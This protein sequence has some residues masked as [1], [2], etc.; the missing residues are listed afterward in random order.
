MSVPGSNL[1]RQALK[2]ITPQTVKYFRF[3]SRTLSPTGRDVSTFETGVDVPQGSVQAVPLS[4]YEMLGLDRQKRYVT[5]FVVR[6]VLGVGRDYSGDQF[7]WG[8]K[9]YDV[10]GETNWFLQDGWVAVIGVEL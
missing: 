8:G 2:L 1:L 10:V 7:E 5:W 9:R 6:A 3:Q 4:R